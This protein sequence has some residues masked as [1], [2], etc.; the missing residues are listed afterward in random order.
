M[1]KD[2]VCGMNVDP[3]TAPA[4]AVKDGKT[5]YFCNAHCRDVF[6]GSA[7]KKNHAQHGKT[8]DGMAT[9]PVCKMQV[10]IARAPFKAT[11]NGKTYYFCSKRCYDTFTGAMDEI[12]YWRNR[13][14]IAAIFGIPLVYL[15]MSQWFGLPA[16]KLEH[17]IMAL[18]QFMLATPIMLASW[19]FFANGLPALFR[20]APNMDTL[21]AVGTLTAYGYSIVVGVFAFLGRKI[22]ELYFE[23]AGILL[24][25]L[26]LGQYLE[27]ITKGKTGEAIKKLLGLQAKTAIVMR[28][29]KETEIP[30]E[31]VRVGDL[32]VVKPGQKIPV[33][34]VIVEGHSSVDESMITGES[35]P[36]EKKKGDTV[37][38]ATL[39]KT[40]SFVFKTTKIGKDTVLAQIV[41]LVEEAQASKAPIQELADRISYYVVPAVIV[42]A[43]LSFLTWTFLGYDINFSLMSFVAVLIIACPCAIGLAT[44]TAI[45]VGTGTGARRGILF[46]NAEAVQATREL[47]VVVFDKTGT[48]TKGEP[49]VT[50]VVQMG[51]IKK[52]QLLKLASGLEKKSEHPLAEAIIKATKGTTPP[53]TGFKAVAGKGVQGIVAGRHVLLGNR[54][55]MQGIDVSHAEQL[56]QKIESQGK[57]AMLLAVDKKLAG[58]I[59]VADTLKE[60]SSA[61]VKELQ[62]LGKRVILLTGDNSRTA[63]G[64]ASQVGISEVIAEVL[65]EQKVA[66]IKELQEQAKV[67]MV[68]DGINDA[69]ALTQADVGIAIG[70]GTDVA[71]ESADV[72][73]VRE[74]LRD[75]V[76]AMR[77]SAY[78]M[79]KIK[80][81]LFWAF[82]YN[83][84]GIPVA[85]GVL[86]PWTG[87]LLNPIIAGAAMAASSISV[88]SNSLMMK[89]KSKTI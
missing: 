38:G 72:I 64:I 28:G 60:H 71:I 27:E 66:K 51:T 50:D 21:I 82:I 12:A 30:I 78:T 76:A 87:W 19:S 25:F 74:D 85:A 36:V 24:L 52:E 42:I 33:D 55:L 49:E 86:Y 10:Q 67:G 35:I 73:L 37:V 40:G 34:G 18:V 23:I 79:R 16:P 59:A 47:D 41:K 54:A 69:P 13:L 44:P 39:N 8:A 80:Q 4:T 2:P 62:S 26:I 84:V 22:G 83:I 48:L 61:A 57:T 89:A 14:L 63:Q 58:I 81:N 68:G 7:G 20:R 56:L 29:K 15:A 11:K 75:V 32:V 77:I 70:S 45:M 43:V 88:V 46:K 31:E 9:D 3:K 65:P 17:H 1:A 6:L 5:Y 53:A